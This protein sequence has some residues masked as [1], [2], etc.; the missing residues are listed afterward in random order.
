MLG[1]VIGGHGKKNHFKIRTMEM[2]SKKFWQTGI[3]PITGYY[4][5]GNGGHNRKRSL[6][7]LN[8]RIEKNKSAKW[9]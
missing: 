6:E 8:R 5:P 2:N 9:S 4:V 7:I 1:L 3:H